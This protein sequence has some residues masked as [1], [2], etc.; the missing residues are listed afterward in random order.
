M[1]ARRSITE[2]LADHWKIPKKYYTSAGGAQ[3]L[4]V[5]DRFLKYY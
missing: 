2:H 4:L 3:P 5:H 1:N